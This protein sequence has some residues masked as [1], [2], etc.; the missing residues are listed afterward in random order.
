MGRRKNDV[1]ADGSRDAAGFLDELRG[2]PMA[3]GDFLAGMRAQEDASLA[4]F[5]ER[6]G[7][8]RSH[9]CDIEQ[10]RRSV[11]ITRA[12]EWSKALGMPEGSLVELALQ[13]M[14]W[15]AGLKDV[16]VRVIEGEAQPRKVAKTKPSP[17]QV[18]TPKRA[19]GR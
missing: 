11:S 9:L 7:I 12:A 6:L 16:R 17:E 14:V 3:I 15:T 10:G 4:A 1:R 13:Q 2:R 18:R 8:S 19:T 5:A